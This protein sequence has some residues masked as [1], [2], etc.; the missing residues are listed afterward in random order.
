MWKGAGPPVPFIF[1]GGGPMSPGAFPCLLLG[2]SA[3]QRCAGG[4][5][6]SRGHAVRSLAGILLCGRFAL[7][8]QNDRRCVMTRKIALFIFPFNFSFL[9]LKRQLHTRSDKGYGSLSAWFVDSAVR[10][11]RNGAGGLGIVV[12]LRLFVRCFFAV[13]QFVGL[14]C[15]QSFFSEI[16]FCNSQ[17]C[18]SRSLPARKFAASAVAGLAVPH[19]AFA[20][21]RKSARCLVRKLCFMVNAGDVLVPKPAG[22]VSASLRR[23]GLRLARLNAG[24]CDSRF[25]SLPGNNSYFRL[26]LPP[27]AY[28]SLPRSREQF[29]M[30]N[31]QFTIL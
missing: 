18:A 4:G 31:S 22:R 30:Q 19:A 15:L 17:N 1:S 25:T 14:R 11:R 16:V 8:T 27:V 10:W 13:L 21:F 12:C 2:T 7:S 3:L 6:V 26:A 5:F 24:V 20:L 23:A 28:S 9:P 29:K